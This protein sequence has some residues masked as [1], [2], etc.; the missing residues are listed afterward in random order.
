L[1]GWHWFDFVKHEPFFAEYM[2]RAG[3]FVE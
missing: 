1:K 3:K 2:K